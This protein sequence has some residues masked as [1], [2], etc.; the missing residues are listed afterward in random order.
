MEF[1]KYV[2]SILFMLLASYSLAGELSYYDNRELKLID[3][4]IFLLKGQ[5][6]VNEV[7]NITITAKI[8]ALQERRD[9][10]VEKFKTVKEA[11]DE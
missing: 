8:K 4:Y 2:L 3:D 5:I 10:I 1:K 11:N 9:E 6:E 7:Q